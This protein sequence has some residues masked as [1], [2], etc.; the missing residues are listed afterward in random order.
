MRVKEVIVIE[1]GEPSVIYIGAVM[2]TT[3]WR[4]LLGFQIYVF[5]ANQPKPVD[6]AEGR[7]LIDHIFD[8]EKDAFKQGEKI[9]REQ[10]RQI[11]R[12]HSR[13]RKT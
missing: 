7:L 3:K 9:V 8:T 1:K 11:S 6:K 12:M 13:Q 5:K 10:L 2:K 4:E